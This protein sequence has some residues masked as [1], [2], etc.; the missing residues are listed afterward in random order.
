M[1]LGEYAPPQSHA[2]EGTSEKS[3]PDGIAC[4]LLTIHAVAHTA[5]ASH[6]CTP[7]HNRGK[8]MHAL[9][10]VPACASGYSGGGP[11]DAP[12]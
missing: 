7:G 12:S 10:P 4:Y 6:W 1:I 8:A 5:G 11:F 3:G 2:R 9:V